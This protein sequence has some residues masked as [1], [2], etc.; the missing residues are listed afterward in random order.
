MQK[1]LTVSIVGVPN[2]GKSTLLNKLIQDKISAISPKPHT[3]RKTALGILTKEDV[4]LVFLDTPGFTKSDLSVNN[5]GDVICFI[6]D[7]LN[8]WRY[9]VHNKIKTLLEQ[10]QNLKIWINKIDTIGKPRLAEI[11]KEIQ[12]LGYTDVIGVMSAVNGIGIAE[13]IDTLSDNALD[14]P[15]LYE[16]DQKHTMTNEEIVKECIREKI[17]HITYHELPY[18]TEVEVR[19]LK[20]SEEGKEKWRAEVVIKTQKEG[21]KI[22]L[23]GKGGS[24]LKKIGQAARLEL[25]TRWGHGSLFTK[26]Q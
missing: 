21:Q 4:Q 16:K 2:A 9:Q 19:E 6:I 14:Y 22:I 13:F 25:I 15:W 11:M 8:P 26:V 18:E 24:V 3:T 1:T 17:F 5:K 23:I 20:F 10:G 12:D 7:G